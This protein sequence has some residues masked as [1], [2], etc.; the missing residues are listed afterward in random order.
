V[1]AAAHPRVLALGRRLERGA[2][3]LDVGS[4]NG[5]NAIPLAEL[6]HR[7][8]ALDY[9][10]EG[11]RRCGDFARER[12]IAD[13]VRLVHAD[14]AAYAYPRGRY[15]LVIAVGSLQNVVK[16]PSG[17]PMGGV[18]AR[19]QG[20]TRKGGWNYLLITA[21]VWSAA[22]PP[23]VDATTL[24]AEELR[25]AWRRGLEDAHRVGPLDRAAAARAVMVQYA[26]PTWEVASLVVPSEGKFHLFALSPTMLRCAYWVRVT[27]RRV[28]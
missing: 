12:G 28:R 5:A 7:V 24:G 15:D 23:G 22:A 11:L 3:V 9:S 4:G 16:K 25:A 18:I 13:R 8:D 26:D 6:G 10:A 14:M 1:P 21:E 19:L 20:A 17:E 2:R 27:A